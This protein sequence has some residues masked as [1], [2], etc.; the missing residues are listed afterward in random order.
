MKDRIFGYD[1]ATWQKAIDEAREILINKARD[2]F[3]PLIT[4]SDLTV[5][6]QAVQ[7]QPDSYALRALLG[8]ISSEE[9]DRGAGMLTVLVV[10]KSGPNQGRPGAGFFELARKLGKL[11][12]G[13]DE[14]DF[15]A[16]ELTYVT[17]F[18]REQPATR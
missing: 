11:G 7:L 3:D 6:I 8:E 9:D 16:A 13:D 14:N 2:S 12:A 5:R 1:P 15:W 18:W 4:Y 10:H 17:N